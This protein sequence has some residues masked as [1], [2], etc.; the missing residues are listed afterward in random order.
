MNK[1]PIIFAIFFQGDDRNYSSLRMSNALQN[2]PT[3]VSNSTGDGFTPNQWTFDHSLFSIY[4]YALHTIIKL[5]N[6]ILRIDDILYSMYNC[7]F[8]LENAVFPLAKYSTNRKKKDHKFYGHVNV[9]N[10]TP[11]LFWR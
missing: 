2:A 6:F 3:C 5:Q 8:L 1:T 7:I 9:K 11:F 10:T 4:P